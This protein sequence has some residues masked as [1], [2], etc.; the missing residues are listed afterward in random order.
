MHLHL[1]IFGR[2]LLSMKANRILVIVQAALMYAAQ[3]PIYMGF[4]LH[5]FNKPLYEEVMPYY[6]RV[7]VILSI[8]LIPICI[9]SIILSIVSIRKGDNKNPSLLMLILKC[10]LMPWFVINFLICGVLC[11][12]MLNPFLLW[13]M[14]LVVS[15]LVFS[16]Y[17]CMVTTSLPD[18]A[19]F[20]G[21]LRNKEARMMPQYVLPI[22][23]MFIFC[24]DAIG[25]LI[26]FITARKL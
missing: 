26:F 14:P 2:I 16:T 18:V 15:I 4:F 3:L 6:V 12:G 13:A 25:A 24:M 20:A 7:Y 19:Y 10:A 8:V 1:F 23:F 9:T 5:H 11:L 17:L 21:K 22:V